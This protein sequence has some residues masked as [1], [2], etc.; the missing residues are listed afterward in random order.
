[1]DATIR[2]E[3]LQDTYAHGRGTITEFNH[4][5]TA[6][7]SGTTKKFGNNKLVPYCLAQLPSFVHYSVLHIILQVVYF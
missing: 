7:Q 5:G 4:E 1:M 6:R 3:G 2:T